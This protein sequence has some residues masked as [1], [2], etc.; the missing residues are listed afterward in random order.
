MDINVV[1][2]DVLGEISLT[3]S[4]LIIMTQICE[5]LNVSVMMYWQKGKGFT[6]VMLNTMN[7]QFDKFKH[8]ETRLMCSYYLVCLSIIIFQ[9]V[10]VYLGLF[11][12]TTTDNIWSLSLN[13]FIYSSLLIGLIASFLIMICPMKSYHNERYNKIHH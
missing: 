5:W 8:R 3:L 10:V 2:L 13:I 1:Y 6:Q 12:T 9:V 11:T 4:Q 7:G